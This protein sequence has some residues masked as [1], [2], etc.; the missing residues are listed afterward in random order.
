M[1]KETKMSIKLIVGLCN[2]GSAYEK[3]RHNAGE[4]FLTALADMYNISPKPEKK[5]FGHIGSASGVMLLLPSTFMNLS[6]QAVQAVANFYKLLPENILI[7]HDELDLPPGIIKL[8]NK[9]GHGGHNGLRDII[10]RLGSKDFYRCRIGIGHPGHRDDVLNYVLGKPS[11][12]DKLSI[13]SAI[14]RASD[15]VPFLQDGKFEKAMHQ[16]H[17]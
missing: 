7:A 4:W 12:S 9:G 1:A 13:L 2:P 6:G 17:T 11:N 14:D 3:T 8:K 16:L 10:S 5:F 15:I